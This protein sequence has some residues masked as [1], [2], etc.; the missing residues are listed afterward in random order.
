MTIN[1]PYHGYVE[2]DQTI[3]QHLETTSHCVPY[4]NADPDGSGGAF[5]PIVA[6]LAIGPHLNRP[7][8]LRTKAGSVVTH[9]ITLRS[10]SLCVLS[11][12]AEVRYKR[13]IPKDFGVDGEQYYM[14]M[15]QKTPDASILKELELMKIPTPKPESNAVNAI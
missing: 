14:F 1:E 5:S 6:T 2:F 15:I 9:K 7:M 3:I 8:F 11:G 4:E 12:R 10:G 13:S